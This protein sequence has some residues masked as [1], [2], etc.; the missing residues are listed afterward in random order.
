MKVQDLSLTEYPSLADSGNK[1]Y[2]GGKAKTLY[3]HMSWLLHIDR[4]WR[5]RKMP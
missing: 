3:G 5:E 4:W 1:I 2:L